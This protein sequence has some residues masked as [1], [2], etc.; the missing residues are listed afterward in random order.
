[1]TNQMLERFGYRVHR[2]ST[3]EAAVRAARDT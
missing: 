1:M 3:P 2:V